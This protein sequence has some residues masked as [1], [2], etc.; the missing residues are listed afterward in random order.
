MEVKAYKN[1]LKLLKSLVLTVQTG[2]GILM[3]EGKM[4]R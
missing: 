3:L 1:I 4:G 2:M